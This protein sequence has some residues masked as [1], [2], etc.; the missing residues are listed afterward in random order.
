MRR[1]TWILLCF[2]SACLRCLLLAGTNYFLKIRTGDDQFTH[3][4]IWHKL[5]GTS[6]LHSA[7]TGKNLADEL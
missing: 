6:E 2:S 7:E 3:A 4:R 5:D 1:L